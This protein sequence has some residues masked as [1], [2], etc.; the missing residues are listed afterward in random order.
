M[1]AIVR[2]MI[3]P[4]LVP[5]AAVIPMGIFA[6]VHAISSSTRLDYAARG[7]HQCRESNHSKNDFHNFSCKKLAS[8]RVTGHGVHPPAKS[9]RH[10]CQ[11]SGVGG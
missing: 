1:V 9:V 5:V 3:I 6:F 2:V 7:Q 11:V 10:R 8:G 4:K